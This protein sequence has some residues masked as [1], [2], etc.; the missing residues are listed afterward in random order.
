MKNKFIAASLLALLS[1]TTLAGCS[2]N[3]TASI[4]NDP[5]VI[6]KAAEKE[7]KVVSFGMADDWANWGGSWHDLKTKY[8]ISHTDTDMNSAEAIHKFETEGKNATADI[9][10]IGMNVSPTA[11]KKGILSKYK[12]TYW[13]KV[14][15]WAKDKDGYWMNAYKGTTAFIIDKKNVAEKDIPKSWA[16]LK[17]G[18]YKVSV[19]SKPASAAQ[20]QYA[21]LAAAHAFGGDESNVKPALDF[22]SS[23]QKQKRLS[24]VDTNVQN[25]K[26]GELDVGIMWDFTALTAR[27]MI[28]ESRFEVIIPSDAAVMSGDSQVI[29]KYA[30]H[31]NAARLARDYI[32]SDAGQVNI[33]KGYARPI[34]DDVKLPEEVKAKLLPASAYH[35]VYTVKDNNVWNKTTL[36]LGQLW[37][38]EV[39]K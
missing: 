21:I 19:G 39:T 37:Q 24:S 16:D 13:D 31:P 28:D 6:Q 26:K 33:A 10:D 1:V 36:K 11:Q 15:A 12:G 30:P 34:R 4:S 23:L 14:P 20:S 29:N 32:L 2:G 38:S 8:G 9:T 22:F 18:K 27:H 35:K 5:K 3:K 17:K 7:K 25:L